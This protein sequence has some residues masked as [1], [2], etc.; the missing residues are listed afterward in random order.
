MSN[1]ILILITT[2]A[3]TG[4]VA[5]CSQ[6]HNAT[7]E[8][9]SAS[10]S[11]SGATATAASSCS[12]AETRSA[13][14]RNQRPTFP[15]Q[16][17]ACERISNVAFDVVVLAKGLDHPWA[18]EPLPGGDLLV[19]EKSGNMRII[20]ANGDMGE[21]IAGVPP[22]L[23]RGQGGLLDVALSPSFSSDRTIFWSY[24][25]PRENGN[26]T[27]VARGVLSQDR[28]KLD[29]VRVI[30]RA[31][32]AYNGSLHFGSRLVFAPDGKLF[33]TLGERSDRAIRPQAQHRDSHMGKIVRINP[34]GS[35]PSDNPFV[36][37]KDTLPEIWTLGHRNVQ[38]A[39][40]DS[41]GRLWTVE[42]GPRGGDELNLIEKGK[43]Y[44]WPVQSFGEEYSG[45]PIDTAATTRPGIQDPVYY[46]DPVIAP[47]GMQF[48]S[49]NAFPAWQGS[50]FIG[51][52]VDEKLVR[53]TLENDRVTGEEHLLEDRN[54]RVRDVR[55]GPDGAL[56]VVTDESNG[57]LWKIAPRK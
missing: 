26:A 3:L 22:V 42:H 6:P 49:G 19:T 10:S 31:L 39:A 13:N 21:P 8:T 44:G 12:P 43:N 9:A 1:Q 25:E 54:Q 14:A 48:Y 4:I 38:S 15:A 30:F 36:G 18:V 27:S 29:Q 37:I 46:W 41:R 45:L 11:E 53:L 57:Q 47:S 28:R 34:D 2:V 35:V 51:G 20:S 52:L 56:Y 33:V 7:A 32:P 16:T 24:T 50:L 55:Q 40:L 5:A 17:R 23:N